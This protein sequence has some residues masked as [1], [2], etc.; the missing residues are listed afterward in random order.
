MDDK[1]IYLSNEQLDN[2]Q[3]VIANNEI[4]EDW[5]VSSLTPEDFKKSN[6]TELSTDESN[7]NVA[8][9]I[10]IT[11]L[12]FIGFALIFRLGLDLFKIS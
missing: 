5:K 4:T 8:V 10:V 6:K 11:L 9:V 12:I 3:R 7:V 1:D 2:L